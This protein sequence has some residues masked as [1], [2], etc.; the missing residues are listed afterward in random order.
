MRVIILNI[1]ILLLLSSC[2]SF[3]EKIGLAHHVPNEFETVK[4]DAL[5]IP[6]TLQLENPETAQYKKKKPAEEKI[7]SLLIGSQQPGSSKKE[8]LSEKA[9]LRKI[10][11]ENRDKNIYRTLSKNQDAEP[12]LHEKIQKTLVFWRKY[13]KGNVID[14]NEEEKK[15]KKK[16]K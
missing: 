14:P 9:L 7:R 5:E 4:N 2:A 15:H 12:T 3:K 13:E 8:S 16:E 10:G 11:A 6:K 1:F